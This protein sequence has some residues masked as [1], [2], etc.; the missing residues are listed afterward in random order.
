[1]NSISEN[2]IGNTRAY[3]IGLLE[4]ERLSILKKAKGGS[5]YDG[6]RPYHIIW[7]SEKESGCSSPRM[8]PTEYGFI[9]PD[10]G[11]GSEIGFNLEPITD[12]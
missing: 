5:W 2:N 6:W 8:L 4:S 9:C 1:M 10:C 12:R 7:K 11:K 3:N